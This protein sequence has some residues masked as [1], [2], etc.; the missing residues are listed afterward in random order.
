M[1][2]SDGVCDGWSVVELSHTALNCC[3]SASSSVLVLD[4]KGTVSDWFETDVTDV[5][6]ESLLQ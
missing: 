6:N 2:D 5:G 3:E 4:D 1:V